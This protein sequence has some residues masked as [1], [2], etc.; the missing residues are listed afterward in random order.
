VK[1][2]KSKNKGNHPVSY[3][4]ELFSLKGKTA[5]IFGGCGVL[6]GEMAIALANSGARVAFLD[7]NKEGGVKCKEKIERAG[8]E[9]TII[10][11]D[12]LKKET[13]EQAISEIRTMW[14]RVDIL[15]N[16]A[17]VNS[18]TPFLEI[19]EEEWEHIM[20][21]NLKG[22][23]TAC[24]VFGSAMIEDEKG[25]TIINVS[26]VSSDIP[27]SKVFT[28]SVSKSGVNNLTKYLA[29]EW[30]EHGI[31]VNAIMPGFFP[32]NQNRKILTEERRRAIFNH[33]P[34]NRF[35]EPCELAGT[36]VWLASDKAAS[37][38]TGAIIPV[39][40][41]FTAMTI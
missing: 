27:L 36:I 3:I 32:A 8:G 22:V 25:G 9:A 18:A 14:G 4:E 17:G 23:F 37:F 1:E 41:G 35:G 29:R 39:D 12:V 26:S 40:G 19:D 20:S 10:Y 13:V 7:R 11:A 2:F 21:V 33:T 24:Q 31:R 5:A 34:M 38:V 15:I 28:Y 16:A 30:A 6:G